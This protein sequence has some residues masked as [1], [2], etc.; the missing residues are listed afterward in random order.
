MLWWNVIKHIYSG[1]VLKYNF[2]VHF[3]LDYTSN[4]GKYCTFFFTPQR[5]I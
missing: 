3:R 2:E 5:D 4:G 1:T